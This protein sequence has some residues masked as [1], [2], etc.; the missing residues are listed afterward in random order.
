MTHTELSW[1]QENKKIYAQSRTIPNSKAIL[2]IVH[3]LCEHSGRY[4]RPAKLFNKNGI[5][6][7][8]V[9]QFGHGKT[10][11]MRGY[12][13]SYEATLDLVNNLMKESTKKEDNI[14]VFFR[15][16]SM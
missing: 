2:C 16:H 13:P 10:E 12:S 9:D 4:A 3:G 8:A 6:V 7:F 15:G 14:P 1:N 11:G 5:S